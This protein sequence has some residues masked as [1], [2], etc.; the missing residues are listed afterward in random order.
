MNLLTRLFELNMVKPELYGWFH[1]LCLV[2]SI[3]LIISLL[4]IK[5]TQ[6]SIRWILGITSVVV[7]LLEIYKQ[8]YC[9]VDIGES[10]SFHYKWNVFPWQFCSTPMYIGLLASIIK[11]QNT[12]YRLCCYLCTYALMAGICVMLYP[13]SVFSENILI[14]IQTMINHGTMVSIGIYLLLCNYVRCEAKTLAEAFKVFSVC[15]S[16]A[17][18][19]N[20]F[21]YDTGIVKDHAF[22]MFYI[23]PHVEGGLPVYGAIQEI[24]PYPL[25][26]FIYILG[27]TL[28][29]GI[30][31]WLIRMAIN[32]SK[33]RGRN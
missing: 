32:F 10:I 12:H 22:N 14:N 8:L 24:V 28:G 9:S 19:L 1:I 21:A 13:S 26:L 20:E 33:N 30:I 29:S 23:S 2:L 16:I 18:V 3:L 4:K 27:F 5:T 7:I 25:N 17:I 31:L 11:N 6:K 15:I